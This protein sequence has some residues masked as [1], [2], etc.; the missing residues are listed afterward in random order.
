MDECKIP[1]NKTKLIFAVAFFVLIIFG[2]VYIFANSEKIANDSIFLIRSN[3]NLNKII[4]IIFILLF[5]L[6]SVYGLKKILNNN[7]G[8]TIDDIGIT[9]HTSSLSTGLIKWNDITEFRTESFEGL[10]FF[11]VFVKNPNEYLDNSTGRKANLLKRNMKN[12]GTP[13]T[14]NANTLK[15]NFDDLEKLLNERLNNKP[16]R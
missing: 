12:Y 4:A 16:N 2:F 13:L 14:I 11:L 9:D 6:L 5:G 8:L 10:K 3:S 7:L 1:I 15:Y